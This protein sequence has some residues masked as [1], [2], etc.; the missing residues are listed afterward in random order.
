MTTTSD[1]ERRKAIMSNE[2]DLT[3]GPW[4]V[5]NHP[6]NQGLVIQTEK[7]SRVATQAGCGLNWANAKLIAAAPDLLEALKGIVEFELECSCS[8]EGECDGQCWH[9]IAIRALEKAEAMQ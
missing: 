6:G 2:T 5:F 8:L 4:V 1:D 9:A 7:G 3:P